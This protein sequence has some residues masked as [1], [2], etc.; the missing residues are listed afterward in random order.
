MGNAFCRIFPWVSTSYDTA[1]TLHDVTGKTQLKYDPFRND[2]GEQPI[3]QVPKCTFALANL[4][5]FQPGF[6]SLQ[7]L[8][9]QNTQRH[10][11]ASLVFSVTDQGDAEDLTASCQP[12]YVD[13]SP[14]LVSQSFHLTF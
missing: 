4:S 6:G 12:K 9:V 8:S 3:L 5:P 10:H 11:N 14:E 2:Q 13:V 1:Y 7:L